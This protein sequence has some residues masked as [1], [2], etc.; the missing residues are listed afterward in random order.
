MKNILVFAPLGSWMVHHQLDCV[1]GA[2]LKLR[3][4]EVRVI[5]CDGIL[6]RCRLQGTANDAAKCAACQQTGNEWFTRFGLATLPLSTLLSAAEREEVQRWAD[7]LDFTHY[8]EASF[9]NVPLGRWMLPL[10]HS[11]LLSGYLDFSLPE[12]QARARDFAHHAA[13]LA[14]ATLHTIEQQRPDHALCYSGAHSYYRVFFEI[15]RSAGIRVLVH[16]RGLLPGSFSLVDNASTYELQGRGLPEWDVWKDIPLST[17]QWQHMAQVLEDRSGGKNVNF[18]RFHRFQSDLAQTRHRLRLHGDTRVLLALASGDW[19]F[20]MAACYGGRHSTFSTQIEWLRITAEL[21]RKNGWH[22]VIRHHPLGAGTATYPRASQFLSELLRDG[23]SLGEHVRVVLPA[24]NLSTYDI[25]HIADAAVTIFSST[26]ADAAIAGLAAVCVG[27]NAFRQIGMDFVKDA[28]DYE[29]ALQRAMSVQP[30]TDAAR[31]SRAYRFQ[32]YRILHSRSV[33]FKS[34]AVHD[35]YGTAYRFGEPE[36]LVSGA[37]PQLDLVCDHILD[38]TPLLAAPQLPYPSPAIEH[39]MAEQ[40]LN[41]LREKRALSRGDATIADSVELSVQVLRLELPNEAGVVPAAWVCRHS[42]VD[43]TWLPID[44]GGG[45]EVVRMTL[46]RTVSKIDAPYVSLLSA[47]ATFDESMISQGVDLLEEDVAKTGVLFGCYTLDKTGAL[48]PEWHTQV[49]AADSADLPPRAIDALHEPLNILSLVLW[50]REKMIPW[51]S[52]TLTEPEADVNW[53]AW[54]LKSFLDASQFIALREPQVF[55]REGDSAASLLASAEAKAEAG[56]LAGA[57]AVAE[58]FAKRFGYIH[59]L[60][61]RMAAWLVKAERY[62][63]AVALLYAEM[64]DGAGDSTTW[65]LLQKTLP[66]VISGKGEYKT[67]HSAVETVHGFMVPGQ[68]RYLHEKV[69]SLPRNASIMEIG[70][71]QGRSTTAMGFACLGTERRILCLDTF[72]GNE[73]IMRNVASFYHKWR[74]NLKRWGLERYA[75]ARMGYSHPLLREMPVVPVFDFVFIDASHEYADV[76]LDF[77]LSYPLV[78]PGGWIGFHDVEPG[79]P[80]SWRVW[81]QTGKPLLINHEVCDTLACG[82]KQANVAW[83]NHEADWP[84][85]RAAY[86]TSVLGESDL[87]DAAQALL[88][89]DKM[90][91]DDPQRAVL[92]ARIA[93]AP[94]RIRNVLLWGVTKEVDTDPWLHYAVGLSQQAIAAEV[95]A[96]HFAQA[97]VLGLQLSPAL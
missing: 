91:A 17:E 77:E 4:C 36:A 8:A 58:V 64:K 27:D 50:R 68:E 14:L 25:L 6:D 38:G 73:G 46:L 12:V 7:A 94:E 71:C 44:A 59:S 57:L 55:L 63:Q 15:C 83:N 70:S 96:R 19:E 10:L 84:G 87:A 35:V 21:C 26:G 18:Q 11:A 49:H 75:S 51:L 42:A 93:K 60:R 76:L 82:Q 32:N 30:A 28:A 53:C 29:A 66:H 23:R 22:L 90:T 97:R 74:G 41:T 16:E 43:F 69:R 48:G 24:E 81:E 67:Y 72:E 95:A 62:S 47:N 92:E 56:D 52:Q 34:V 39:H 85:F 37:D 86:A 89:L 78:K 9:R 80:G 79:W 5:T 2:A 61:N 33:L 3:G 1:I 65:D 20:S 54:L 31:L 13:L 40:T 45:W 88:A